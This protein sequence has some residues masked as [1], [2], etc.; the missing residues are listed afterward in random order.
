MNLGWGGGD[1]MAKVHLLSFAAR[2][3]DEF[4]FISIPFA[5]IKTIETLLKCILQNTE[6]LLMV[7]IAMR[8]LLV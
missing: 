7:S 3:V 8:D 2:P 6:T 5:N 4:N 1:S